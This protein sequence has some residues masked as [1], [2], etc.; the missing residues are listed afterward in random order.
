MYLST[1]KSPLNV[2]HC[3]LC[4]TI[5]TPTFPYMVR[6]RYTEIRF[7]PDRTCILHSRKCHSSVN[8]KYIVITSDIG[9]MGALANTHALK[10]YKYR[11][12]ADIFLS[13]FCLLVLFCNCCFLLL[14]G[15]KAQRKFIFQLISHAKV[16]T[17]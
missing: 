2:C 11:E 8:T 9:T 1:D 12:S 14:K 4:S 16:S 6:L 7:S 10:S 13:T 5:A 3:W 15:E 17:C